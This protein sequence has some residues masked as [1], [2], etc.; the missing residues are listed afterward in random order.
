MTEK[1][2]AA[3]KLKREKA[4]K[5][6]DTIRETLRKMIDTTVKLIGEPMAKAKA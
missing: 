2:L 4:E 5:G 3:Y 1:Q 6:L